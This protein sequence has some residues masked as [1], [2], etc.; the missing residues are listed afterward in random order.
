MS[1]ETVCNDHDDRLETNLQLVPSHSEELAINVDRRPIIIEH[2]ERLNEP[3]STVTM[4][5]MFS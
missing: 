2:R 1:D 3:T 5:P 4:S